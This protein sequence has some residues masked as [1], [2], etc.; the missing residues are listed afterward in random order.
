MITPGQR[1]FFGA[2][3]AQGVGSIALFTGH[4]SGDQWVTLILGLVAIYGAKSVSETYVNR[5]KAP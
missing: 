5:G 4:L 1:T 2:M 3:A